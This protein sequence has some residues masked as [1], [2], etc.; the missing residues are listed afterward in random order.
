MQ[1]NEP[2][3]YGLDAIRALYPLPIV[4]IVSEREE[5]SEP[6]ALST[7]RPT[8]VLYNERSLWTSGTARR[9]RAHQHER[10]A[11]RLASMEELESK[12]FVP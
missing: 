12:R 4:R 5:S 6:R 9:V 3:M 8:R 7:S 10:G 11:R 1:A 2:T